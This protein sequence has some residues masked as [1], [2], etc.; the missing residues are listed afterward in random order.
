MRFIFPR[1]LQ[2]QSSHFQRRRRTRLCGTSCRLSYSHRSGPES[3]AAFL[4]PRRLSRNRSSSQ[5]PLAE[6][7]R[8]S[9]SWPLLHTLLGKCW[10]RDKSLPTMELRRKWRASE[11]LKFYLYQLPPDFFEQKSGSLEIRSTKSWARIIPDCGVTSRR[12]SAP[13]YA[14]STYH[15]TLTD[16]ANETIGAC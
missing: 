13:C 16:W 9:A 10:C 6:C 12:T 2:K 11:S 15:T 14:T 5:S 4:S 3:M 8:W 1:C 7:G